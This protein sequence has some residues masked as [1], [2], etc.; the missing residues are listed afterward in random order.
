MGYNCVRSLSGKRNG[1]TRRP[2]SIR[3]TS[4]T[5]KPAPTPIRQL[6]ASVDKCPDEGIEAAWELFGDP[7]SDSDIEQWLAMM[8]EIGFHSWPGGSGRGVLPRVHR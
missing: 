5:A 2:K 8:S 6:A 1:A 7:A 3:R 4:A